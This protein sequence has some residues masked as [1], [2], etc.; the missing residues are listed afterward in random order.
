MTLK[1]TFGD[2]ISFIGICLDEQEAKLY[3]FKNQY[4]FDWT[5][6]H[7]GGDYNLIDQYDITALPTNILIDRD[8][9]IVS[10][11]AMKPS[12]GL[13]QEFYLKFRPKDNDGHLH[14]DPN[15]QPIKRRYE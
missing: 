5:L 14:G 2:S 15:W 1:E 3:H 13:M 12:E 11:P 7:F 8:G 6:L 9:N 4:K 10:Y